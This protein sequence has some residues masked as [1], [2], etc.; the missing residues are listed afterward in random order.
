MLGL[1]IGRQAHDLVLVAV[2]RKTEVLRQR[3]IED[4]ERMC[5]I[6]LS[7]DG[8]RAPATQPPGRACE[9]TEAVHRDGGGFVERRNERCRSEVREMVVKVMSLSP[10]ALAGE[11]L[12]EQFFCTAA[13]GA[14]AQFL[15]HQRS[16][17]RRVGKVG[18]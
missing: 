8:H 14:R 4:A 3:L 5:E 11:G 16:E 17:E 7:F 9:V 6:H 13:S 2:M 1:P 18:G 12:S 10:E 15:K